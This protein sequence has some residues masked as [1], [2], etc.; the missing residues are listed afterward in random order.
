MLKNLFS[1]VMKEPLPL[2]VLGVSESKSELNKSKKESL[3]GRGISIPRSFL[4]GRESM[5]EI[6][7][8]AS[9]NLVTAILL[10]E[11]EV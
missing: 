10:S 11:I 6:L 9:T 5:V 3:R 8:N 1:S 2:I 7:S 4:S